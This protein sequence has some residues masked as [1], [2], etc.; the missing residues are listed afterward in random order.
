M[1]S[2]RQICSGNVDDARPEQQPPTLHFPKFRPAEQMRGC[3]VSIVYGRAARSGV[4]T[5]LAD[6]CR[7]QTDV[8]NWV[9]F[10]RFLQPPVSDIAIPEFLHS[11]VAPIGEMCDFRRREC[12]SRDAPCVGLCVE[13]CIDTADQFDLIKDVVLNGRCFRT[14]LT[15]SIGTLQFPR[16]EST[17]CGLLSACVKSLPQWLS[18]NARFVFILR[19]DVDAKRRLLFQHFAPLG[20][21]REQ[22]D[23]A[24]DACTESYRCLVV[25]RWSRSNEISDALFWYQASLA[26]TASPVD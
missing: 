1:E 10:S 19:E 14:A 23:V 6:L 26:E 17:D 2:L 13:H 4:S 11:S 5:L 9:V 21:S 16:S 22:F 8:D 20:C 7:Q 18:R 12:A 24:L 3:F 25:D 15:L